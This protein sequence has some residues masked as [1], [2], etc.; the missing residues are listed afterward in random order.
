M[1][2]QRGVSTLSGQG[3]ESERSFL[4]AQADWLEKRLKGIRCRLKEFGEAESVT[5]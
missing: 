5:D 4:Q 3:P 1:P 2:F